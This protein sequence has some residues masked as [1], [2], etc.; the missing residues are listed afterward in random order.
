[1]WTFYDYVDG[2]GNNPFHEWLSE[3]SKKA[4]AKVHVRL[5]DL[6]TLPREQWAD[7]VGPLVGSEWDG[8]YEIRFFVDKKRIRPLFC[9]GP[10]KAEATLLMGAVE[11]DREIEPK[12][13]ARTCQVRRAQLKGGGHAVRHRFD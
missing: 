12:S 2:R 1:M 4:R 10:G 5:R 3:L 13:A 8:I 11:I 7:W 6:E 9:V